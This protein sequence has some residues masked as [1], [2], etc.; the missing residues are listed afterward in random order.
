MNKAALKYKLYTHMLE[1]HITRRQ[2]DM[3]LEVGFLDKIKSFFGGG[4]EIGGDLAK[5]F[6]DKVNQ[7]QFVTAKENITK[8]VD[9]LKKVA[10]KAGVGDDVVNQFLK[11]VL[12]GAGVDPAEVASSDPSGGGEGASAGEPKPGAPIKPGDAETAV[13]ALAGAAAEASGQDPEKGREQAEEKKVTPDKATEVLSKAIAAKAGVDPKAAAAVVKALIDSGHLLAEGRRRKLY[14]FDFKNAINEIKEMQKNTNFF[15]RWS[16][17]A[18]IDSSPKRK[19]VKE[20]RTGDILKDI[21]SG[22]IKSLEDLEKAIDAAT[23]D[24]K[25]DAVI[26][27]KDEIMKAF[28]EK[29]PDVKPEE[30]KKAE[31]AIDGAK[32]GDKG[33]KE[34][35]EGEKKAEEAKKKF[36]AAFEDVKKA[37]GDAAD[38]AAIGKI[39][40]ALDEL[41][42]LKIG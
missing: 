36:S 28:K 41:D 3:L 40:A 20:G 15:D 10:S 19:V 18:G 30:E 6:K 17:L 38:E 5:L 12:D 14:V 13:P 39:L 29:V 2:H 42:S 7:K 31:E 26:K 1:G 34:D 9:D 32:E 24:G 33:G 4:M 8:A 25:G 22:N 21:E 35:K 37:V 11:S 23:K 16:H 27:R